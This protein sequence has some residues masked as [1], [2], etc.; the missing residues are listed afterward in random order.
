MSEFSSLDLTVIRILKHRDKY[1]MLRNGI[2]PGTLEA[3]AE[4]IVK[5]LGKFFKENPDVKVA[6]PTKFW[7]YFKL[8]HPKLKDEGIAIMSKMIELSGEDVED[9]IQRGITK[10]LL[11]A[12][13]ALD[14][15]AALEKWNSGEE[16]DLV[17]YVKLA[18]D[19]IP[20]GGDEIPY[21]DNDIAAMLEEDENDWGFK[22]RLSCMNASM[23]PLREGDFG[24]VA[25]RV[26]RGKTT[27]LVSE[28]THMAQQVRPLFN[29]D[30]PVIYLNNEGPGS[31]IVKRAY[32]AAL[33]ADNDQLIVWSKDGSLRER[34]LEAMGGWESFLVIDVHDRPM[35]F[36]EQVIQRLNPSLVVYDMLDVV[37]FDGGLMNGGTRTDQILEAAYQR[38]RLLSVKYKHSAIAASQ[39]SAEAEGNPF[40]TLGMLA[41]S[42][43][44][45]PGAA[46][47][48]AMLGSSSD[49][50]MDNIR[51]ISLPKNKLAR[52]GSKKDPRQQVI[53][54]GD[55][56]RVSNPI[57]N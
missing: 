49:P 31:R 27:W 29:E 19:G 47:W 55:I 48:V 5:T 25:G 4:A 53:F 8:S 37:P 30:R 10:R 54:E 34:Y 15:T 17:N 46:D 24:I 11:E 12:R 45:K 36:L 13:I 51:W 18:A 7:P 3:P 16:L 9:D 40:P 22:W 38:G 14:M 23:R 6:T 52:T 20:V 35:S 28:L 2:L 21:A 42:K 33:G 57:N 1:D 32:Q 50:L 56:A 26:D 44:G 41:N 39:L 43:T